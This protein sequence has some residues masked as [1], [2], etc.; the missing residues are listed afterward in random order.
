MA[1]AMRHRAAKQRHRYDCAYMPAREGS[2]AQRFRG[3]GLGSSRTCSKNA[4]QRKQCHMQYVSHR[5]ATKKYGPL[6]HLCTGTPKKAFHSTQTTMPHFPHFSGPVS[7]VRSIRPPQTTVREE[8]D[9]L[10]I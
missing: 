9:A 4:A 6:S 10:G 3:Q 7:R 5:T 1:S 2:K 8:G